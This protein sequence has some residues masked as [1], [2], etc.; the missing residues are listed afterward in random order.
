MHILQ[1]YYLPPVGTQGFRSPE[2]SQLV[3]ASHCDVIA[4]RLSPL[5][6]IWS[7]GV[8]MLRL[9]VGEDG[10]NTQRQVRLTCLVVGCV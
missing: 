10:P 6:D 2:G 3:V 1:V 9:F 8:L 7:V 5:S 4:P